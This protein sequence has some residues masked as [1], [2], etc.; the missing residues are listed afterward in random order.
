M[1]DELDPPELFSQI[2]EGLAGA[3]SEA[4]PSRAD[5]SAWLDEL[6]IVRKFRRQ[7]LEQN[8]GR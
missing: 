7:V 5:A 4:D 8:S 3:P 6:P 1:D 2:P